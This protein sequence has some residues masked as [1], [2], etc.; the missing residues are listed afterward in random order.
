MDL[1]MNPKILIS[2]AAYILGSTPSA[3]VVSRLVAGVD[4]RELGDGNM[5]AR[6]VT[7]NLGW[8]P[9]IV[10]A[11]IDVG[12]GVLA[13]L[14]AQAFDLSL[15]WQIVTGFCAVLGH[16]FP[17][18]AGFRGGQGLAT[19]LGVLLVLTPVESLCGLAVYGV[20]YLLT[21]HSDL[22]AS[23]GIGLLVFLIWK[24]SEPRQLLVSSILMILSVPV[25]TLLDRPRRARVRPA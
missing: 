8:K 9:G 24:L 3:L 23:A 1:N 14:L 10:V 22:S 6:N 13:V 7:R 19:T 4:I 2:L 17:I 25:K 12:K 15:G 18:F 20:L 16:D 11:L 5:G 21:R